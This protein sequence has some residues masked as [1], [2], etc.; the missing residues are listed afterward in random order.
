MTDLTKL[1]PLVDMDVLL[2]STGFS[3]DSSYK[4]ELQAQG[5]P[6]DLIP[7]MLDEDDYTGWA[8]HALT[9]Q[10]DFILPRF[11]PDALLYL[12][13]SGNFRE[14]IATLKPYKGNRDPT[15]KPKYYREVKDY[16][17]ERLGAIVVHGKEADDAMATEQMNN[18]DDSTIIVTIDKDLNQVPGHHY[19]PNKD[20]L[21]YVTPGEADMW[22]WK[23]MLIGDTADNIPGINKIG[24]KRADG[25]ITV[26]DNDINYKIVS[27]LYQQQYNDNWESAI[28][29][30]AALLWMQ[31]SDGETCPFV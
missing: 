23:Q 4:K 28:K 15:H 10:L 13:G 26:E 29:E 25:L 7:Q 16:M 6:D 20:L 3:A 18:P 22:F 17:I 5:V 27:G 8:I 21:Y 24:P 2:Y 30:V 9:K 14:H 12:T 19:N 1:H 31:R 11:H